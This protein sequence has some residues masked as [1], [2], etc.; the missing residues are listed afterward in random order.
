MCYCGYE[1][2]SEDMDAEKVNNLGDDD[3]HQADLPPEFCH[4]HDEG[5]E[6]ATAHLGYQSSC[7]ECPF[8][9]CIYDERGGR[10][11]RA[12]RLR[13]QEIARLFHTE[14]KGL[15]ELA[16]TFGVSQRTIQRA[17][18]KVKNERRLQSVTAD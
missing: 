9:Q 3:D 12:K 1:S 6:L 5:C 18:K 14:G 13:D 11:R 2:R 8:P 10:Q 15:K 4:Y 17:L 16:G 7:L